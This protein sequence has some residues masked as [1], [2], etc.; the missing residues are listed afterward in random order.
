M[1]PVDWQERSKITFDRVHALNHQK[2]V[3]DRMKFNDAKVA[4]KHGHAFLSFLGSYLPCDS[5][6][7]LVVLRK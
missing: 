4:P 1:P 7:R 3:N 5:V 2:R 6:Y